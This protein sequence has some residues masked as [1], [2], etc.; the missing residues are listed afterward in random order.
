MLEEEK[1]ARDVYKKMYERYG[2][3]VFSN[4]S[5]SEQKHMDQIL[6]LLND[7]AIDDPAQETIGVFQN[8]T[9]QTLYDNL[10]KQ[11][12]ISLVEAL[13]VGATIEDVD[14]YDLLDFTIQTENP[15]IISIF[16]NLTSGSR[17]HMRTFTK[18]LNKN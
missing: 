3:K 2:L 13:K 15:A 9:L 12:N 16:E 6:C 17:N 7:Y 10:T 8:S 5:Q 4:I 11:G 1:L 18:Q 14:I